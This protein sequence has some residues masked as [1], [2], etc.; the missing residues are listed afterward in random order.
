MFW[1]HRASKSYAL[2]AGNHV[3]FIKN[4]KV[5]FYEGSRYL[6]QSWHTTVFPDIQNTSEAA[7]LRDWYK[8]HR[9]LNDGPKLI[10]DG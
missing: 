6:D 4:A 7:E 5:K 2:A 10:F 3:L 9:Q 1:D 8:R